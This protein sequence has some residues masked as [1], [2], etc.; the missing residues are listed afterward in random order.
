MKKGQL[1]AQ[2]DP[3]MFEAQ[4]AQAKAN[5]EKADA[6]FRDAD[7]T[8]KR[9]RELFA[10]NLIPRSDLD[11]AE[12]NFDSAKAQSGSRSK[13]SPHSGGDRTSDTHASCRPLT[14]S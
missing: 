12:T 6:A 11:T 3:E 8:L 10:K 1:I 4:V 5:V 2:I 7:R 14:A 13:G 9:N